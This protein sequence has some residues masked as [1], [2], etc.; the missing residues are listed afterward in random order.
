MNAFYDSNIVI[1]QATFVGILLALSIQVPLRLGVFSF[2]G[3][4]FYGIGAYVGGNVVI[5]AD[6]PALP[7]IAAGAA[8]SAVIGLV[9]GLVL[10]RLN[11]LYLAMATV[12]FDLMVGVVAVNGGDWT[13]GPTGLYGILTDLTLPI[14]LL[15]VGVFLVAAELSER[16]RAHRRIEAVREDPELAASMGIRVG[17]YRVAGFVISGLVGGAAG[18]MNVMTRTTIGPADVGFGLVILA[19]TMIIVGGALS[20][21]GAVLGA[22]LFTWLPQVLTFVGEWQELVYG[23]VVLL[24]GIF[25]PQG[26]YGL[27]VDGRRHLGTRRRTSEPPTPPTPISS[28]VPQEVSL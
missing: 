28:D 26:L 3:A 24:A 2:A 13:G 22:I 27:W 7:A 12:A 20:W 10:Q 5:R 1:I 11:G 23:C 19:L 18:A 25:L 17:T 4:G 8:A 16:G 6:L 9:L 14:I 15:V 21:R